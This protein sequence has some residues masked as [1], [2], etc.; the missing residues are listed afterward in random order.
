MNKTAEGTPWIQ[1]AI[2]GPPGPE[3]FYIKYLHKTDTGSHKVPMLFKTSYNLEA[4]VWW[5]IS[6]HSLKGQI[7][8]QNNKFKTLCQINFETLFW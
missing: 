8:S 5:I 7:F 6:A 4:E 1:S 3:H 2:N